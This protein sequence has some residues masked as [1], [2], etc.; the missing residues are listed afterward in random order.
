[1]LHIT[2]HSSLRIQALSFTTD[3]YCPITTDPLWQHPSSI[4]TESADFSEM[5]GVS[6]PGNDGKHVQRVHWNW[7][8]QGPGSEAKET[9]TTAHAEG[10]GA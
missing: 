2:L 8:G 6:Q 7:R 4:W 3:I 10:K 1:M 5:G 9:A